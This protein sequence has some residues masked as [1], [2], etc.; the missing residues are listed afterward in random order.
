MVMASVKAFRIGHP[1]QREVIVRTLDQT[2][3]CEGK[4]ECGSGFPPKCVIGAL[5]VQC[6]QNEWGGW[7]PRN[8]KMASAE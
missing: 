5:Y 1:E 7:W 3:Y 6:A 2:Q 4:E 8:V